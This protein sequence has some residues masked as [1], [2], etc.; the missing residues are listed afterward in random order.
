MEQFG[1]M[2]RN[3]I[4]LLDSLFGLLADKPNFTAGSSYRIFILLSAVIFSETFDMNVRVEID[5]S[6]AM[7]CQICVREVRK[8]IDG[9]VASSVGQREFKAFLVGR[10]GKCPY[11]KAES[12]TS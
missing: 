11:M 3:R 2:L 7:S 12:G 4:K 5:Q 1:L 8:T 10:D 6:S 9:F